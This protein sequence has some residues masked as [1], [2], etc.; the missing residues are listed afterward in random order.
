AHP[1]IGRPR[2][3]VV[4]VG[5]RG[6]GSFAGPMSKILMKLRSYLSLIVLL[7]LPLALQAAP[8]KG[9]NT[10]DM[11]QSTFAIPRIP[12][13]AR[14]PFFPKAVSLYANAAGPTNA[15]QAS[16]GASL[17]KLVGL[18]DGV[19]TINRQV[20]TVGETQEVKTPAGPVSVKL[21]QIKSQ[22]ESVII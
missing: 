16:L 10:V 9:T 20:L 8:P 1:F 18:G 21:V 14:D 3:A 15:P 5:N 19:A 11:Q 13:E 4:Q 6:L 17:L 12:K 22:D 7:G 2:Q